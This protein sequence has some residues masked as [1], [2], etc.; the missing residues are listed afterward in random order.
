MLKRK[1]TCLALAVLMALVTVISVPASGGTP[2]AEA[3]AAFAKG[4]DISWVPGMEAQGKVWLDK[5]GKQRDILDILKND[6]QINSVRIRVWV[7]PNMSDYA[8]GYMNATNAAKLA[9]RAKNAGLRVMLTLHYSDSWADPGKQTKPAAWKSL[10]FQQ[11]M[12]TLYSYTVSVMNTMKSYG[13][14]PEWV[15]IGNET[16]NGLLWDDGKAS[17]N[18]K[19]YAWLINTG[20][21]AVKSVSSSTK[22]IVHLANG[23]DN[24]TTRWNIGG[25]VSNG[26]NFDIVAISLYPSTSDWQTK[27]TQALANLNDMVN[28]YGKE[29]MVTEIGMDYSQPAIAKNFVTDIKNKVRNIANS[30]GLGVFYWEPEASPG[31]NG[32]YNLGAWGTNNRP[33]AALE[34]FLN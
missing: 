3:A 20:H 14:T 22:T 28:T 5:N 7:N 1:L 32:G 6:Y 30:K 15:Q 21:N 31:Y 26:A 23:F 33:T 19:N 12:D 4:A 34:G 2:K 29:V 17:V 13:V 10:T 8:N 16:L 11:L 9:Q 27:D 24:T 25:L 18:M